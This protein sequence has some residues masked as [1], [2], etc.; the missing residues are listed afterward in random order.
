MRLTAM[1][2][3]WKTSQTA[4]TEESEHW[5]RATSVSPMEA[6]FYIPQPQAL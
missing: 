2:D 4:V 1:G 6:A 5:Q 3:I